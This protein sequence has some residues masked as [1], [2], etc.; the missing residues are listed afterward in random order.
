MRRLLLTIFLIAVSLPALAAE[1][2]RVR[3]KLDAADL[4]NGTR[5]QAE[6]RVYY[7][8][9]KPNTD[10]SS[11]IGA[12]IPSDRI[13]RLDF[14]APLDSRKVPANFMFD[15]PQPLP[16]TPS[17][18]VATILFKVNLTIAPTK[19][20][21]LPTIT[22]ERIFAMDAGKGGVVERCLR[23]RGPVREGFFFIGVAD[24]AQPV[25][26]RPPGTDRH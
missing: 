21:G 15:F 13:Y 25:M 20:S 9:R 3:L 23:L 1:P 26:Q 8:I 4:L 10:P 6:V 2:P 12:G 5:Y 22:R 14:T 18:F 19:D 24:C 7:A 17:G 16:I 11:A